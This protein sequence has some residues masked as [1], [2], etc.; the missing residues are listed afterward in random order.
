MD[1]ARAVVGR[2]PLEPGVYRF[3]D[4]TERVIYIGRASSLRRRVASHFNS[5]RASR[6]ARI[7]AVV[8]ESEHEAA[9]LERNLLEQGLPRWNRT[10]GGQEVPVFIC[11]DA[12]SGTPGLSVVHSTDEAPLAQHF[13]PYLGGLRVR[14]AVSGLRR[15]LPLSYAGVSLSGFERDMA[16]LRQVSPEQRPGF[17]DTLGA[18]LAREPTAVATVRS[19]LIEVRDALAGKLAFELA[20]QL[21]IELAAFEWV[22]APQRV[23]VPEPRDC[24]VYGYESGILLHFGIRGGRL[25]RWTQRECDH[26]SA[27]EHVSRCPPDWLDF[28]QR[29]AQ[30]ATRLLTR[31][32]ESSGV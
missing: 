8:C 17:L 30:L 29:N 26:S 6:I 27:R 25:C 32:T 10:A 2:L 9:W 20:A 5:P 22:V 13:G 4:S 18:C 15:V 3:R 28:A 12:R 11:V 14:Q 21:Q 23:T 7:E 16:R 19:M 1:A 31:R 24:D